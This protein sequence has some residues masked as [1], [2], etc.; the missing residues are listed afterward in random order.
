MPLDTACV[1]RTFSIEIETNP[2]ALIQFVPEVSKGRQMAI[3]IKDNVLGDVRGSSIVHIL[4]TCLLATKEVGR[5]NGLDH[6]RP[7][8]CRRKHG[9]K[10][11]CISALS[12]GTNEF[13]IEILIDYRLRT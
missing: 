12:K 11:S 1:G 7:S 6:D 2:S 8:N 9:G 5:G 3:R 4:L 10:L 13:V